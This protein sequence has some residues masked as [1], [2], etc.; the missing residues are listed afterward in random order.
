[1]FSDLLTIK[2]AF[3]EYKDVSPK[4]RIL[5]PPQGFRPEG[6]IPKR[7]SCNFGVY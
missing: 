5:L 3:L 7:H 6:E 1:M 2:E 4:S